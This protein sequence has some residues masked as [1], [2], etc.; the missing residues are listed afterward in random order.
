MRW[1][2]RGRI[3]DPGTFGRDAG[4]LRRSHAQLPVVDTDAGG[5]WR[6]Y[7]SSRDD[8]GRSRPFWI[9]VESGQP[10]NV[11]AERR[12]PV[13]ALGGRGCFDEHGVMPSAIVDC[14]GCKYLY[15]IG[16]S[17]RLSVPYQNAIGLAVSRDGGD[18]F[19]RLAD[20][21]VIGQGPVDPQFTG[22]IDVVRHDGLWHACYM[23]CTEWRDTDDG[24]E[25]RYLLKHAT[26][27]DGIDWRRDGRVLIGYRDDAE[28]GIVGASLLKLSG[29]WRM[30][31]SYRGDR[32]F[33]VRGP[34]S[35]RIGMADSPDLLH[36]T[37]RDDEAGIDIAD[38]GWDSDMICYPEVVAHDGRLFM[39][40]NGNGFGH[41]GIGHA[42]CKL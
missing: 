26:S 40:Y 19:E 22:T 17:R 15:Y 31:Y 3:V 35:Y 12:D 9:E 25:P 39:F 36:W 27:H 16:W 37:R 30:W 6:L 34:A 8:D 14:D 5:R 29:R 4:D 32:G 23:S 28:G 21:P 7:F 1:T 24:P 2:R 33:R 18:S 20:G 42:T 38:T 11:L 13:L 10:G 41:T